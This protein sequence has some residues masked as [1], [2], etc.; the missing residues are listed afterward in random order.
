MHHPPTTHQP[1]NSGFT[2]LELMVVIVLIGI[3]SATLIPAMHGTYEAEL[4]HAQS[5]RLTEALNLAYSRAITLNQPHRLRL[6]TNQ[7]RFYIEGRTTSPGGNTSF[8]TIP[9]APG[10]QGS[11]DPRIAIHRTTQPAADNNATEPPAPHLHDPITFFPDGTATATLLILQ[12]RQGFRRTLRI[13]PVTARVD[14]PQPP[15]P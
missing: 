5:R 8:A 11:L 9:Y 15:P 12:D 14:S 7:L 2:L 6:N 3:L 10:A 13:N 1:P 4:L